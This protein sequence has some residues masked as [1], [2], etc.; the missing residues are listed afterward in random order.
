MLSRNG[1]PVSLT[2]KSFAVLAYL[3]DNPGRLVTKK[4]LLNAAW[5]NVFVQDAVLKN[6]ILNRTS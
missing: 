3:I 2:P 6:C 5:S 1:E 4:E